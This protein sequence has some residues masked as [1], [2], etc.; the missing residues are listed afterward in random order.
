[1]PSSASGSARDAAGQRLGTPAY[2]SPEQAEGDLE[3]LGP[4]SDVYSLG[5]TLYC[6][7]TGRPPFEGD[8][9]E[10]IRAVQRGEFRPPRQLDPTIDRALE[11]VCLKAMAHRPADRYASPRAW[12]TTSSAGWPTSRS[13]P[14]A[15]RCSPARRRWANRNRTAVASAAVALVAGVVG[16]SAVLAVQTQAKAAIAAALGRET[17]ANEGLAAANANWSGRRRRCRRGTTWRWTRSRRSTP[18]SARTS[19]SRRSNSRTCGTGC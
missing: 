12:P 4:R 5:G 14:G 16:L 1:M 11:A 13:R 8:I 2:M 9:D 10:V 3:H 15:S 18:G 6:L 19:C 7:L 17:Q